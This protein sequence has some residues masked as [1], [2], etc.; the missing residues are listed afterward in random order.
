MLSNKESYGDEALF[1]PDVDYFGDRYRTRSN[2]N[3]Q[4]EQH[5]SLSFILL[6][7]QALVS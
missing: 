5:L 6:L 4:E 1:D 7:A 3:K 2:P